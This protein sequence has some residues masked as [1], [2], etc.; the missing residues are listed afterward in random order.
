MI[1]ALTL[2]GLEAMMTIEG[3]TDGDVFETYVDQV[4]VPVLLPGDIV[5]LDNLGA[6]RTAKVRQSIEAAGCLLVFQPPYSPDFNPIELA[7]SKLKEFLR[8]ARARTREGL[9]NAVAM[10]MDLVTP[11]DA[12]GWFHHCGVYGQG[13]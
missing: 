9:D 7:W 5:V 6:H 2:N 13:R 11:D 3:G 1:G 4:L 10:A 12:Y 8:T